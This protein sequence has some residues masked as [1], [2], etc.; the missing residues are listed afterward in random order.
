MTD[1]ELIARSK[2]GDVAASEE[3]WRRYKRAV[4]AYARKFFFA[5]GETEDLIQ[6]G[7]IGFF[8]AVNDYAPE[9]EGKMSFK[10]FAYLCV[11]RR[12]SDEVKK[13]RRAEGGGK[14]LSI[15]QENIDCEDGF[16]PVDSLIEQENRSEFWQKI[17]KTLSSFEFRV[18][19]MYL[20]GMSYG[21]MAA[22]TGK[23]VKSVDNALSRSKKK[24]SGVY[25]Q[26]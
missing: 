2:A 25:A 4:C 10:N 14:V 8:G 18:V 13:I 17:G 1:E 19:V 20:D 23:S 3:L 11:K 6:E 16:D 21:E 12:I 5:G 22:A 24:L 7:M 9:K 26:G 15:E